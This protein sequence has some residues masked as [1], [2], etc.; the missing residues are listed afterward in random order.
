[1]SRNRKQITCDCDA[2]PF[3]HRLGGGQCDP[4]KCD[5]CF[6]G[7]CEVHGT[8]DSIWYNPFTGRTYRIDWHPS[9]TVGERN[10]G[11]K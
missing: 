1:M 8:D 5:A 7:Y 9:L 10:P 11:L 3:P 6:D 4:C 2:Y